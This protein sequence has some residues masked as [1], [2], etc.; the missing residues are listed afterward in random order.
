MVT[1]IITALL[2]VYIGLALGFFAGK[3]HLVDNQN[4]ASLNVLLMQFALPLTLF[5]SIARTPQRV[6]IENGPLALVLAGG[7]LI[8]YLAVFYVQRR[9]YRLSLGD[10]AVQTL[11]IAFPNFASIGLPL[12]IPIFGQSAALPVAIAIA[13]GSITIS[14]LTLALIEMH[15]AQENQHG[16]PASAARQFIVALGHSVQKPIFIGPVLGLVVALS[17]ISLPAIVGTALGPMT[18][19]TAGVGL[20]L[21]GLMLSAQPIHL[22]SNVVFGTLVKNVIQP[23]VVLG[24]VLLFGIPWQIGVQAVL[25]TAIPAGFFGLVFGASAGLRPPVSGATLVVSSVLGAIT[26]SLAIYVWAPAH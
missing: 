8:V 23:L 2:P 7:L 6:I 15:R 14:P 9:V 19:A 20:F 26:L 10:S 5:V 4:V 3:R 17:G 24:L 12:L 16:Q 25:L 11:T 18:S 22:G 13:V 21:T 1:L